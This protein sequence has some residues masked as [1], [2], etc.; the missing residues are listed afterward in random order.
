MN[1][2]LKDRWLLCESLN[3][4]REYIYHTQWPRFIGLVE[5]CED[6]TVTIKQIHWIDDPH[7]CE[8]AR[9]MREAGDA[10]LEYY[11]QLEEDLNESDNQ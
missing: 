3:G 10:W 4:K 11:N 2:E 8:A 9:L 6:C 5:D 1:L 7:H